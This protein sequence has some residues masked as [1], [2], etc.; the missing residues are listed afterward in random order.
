M[1]VLFTLF[2]L[3]CFLYGA[4]SIVYGHPV[5]NRADAIWGTVWSIVGLVLM[6]YV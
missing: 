5:N 3:F 1:K 2:F 6:Q 4:H